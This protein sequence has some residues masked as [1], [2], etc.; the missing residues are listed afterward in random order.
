MKSVISK[1]KIKFD[2]IHNWEIGYGMNWRYQ[3]LNV[4]LYPE[5]Q[6]CVTRRW[7]YTPAKSSSA[8]H[9]IMSVQCQY[10]SSTARWLAGIINFDNTCCMSFC[11]NDMCCSSLPIWYHLVEKKKT[12]MAGPG[13]EI[14]DLQC[15]SRTASNYVPPCST[16][17]M[18]IN[19]AL[20]V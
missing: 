11:C 2:S 15:N 18:F 6:Y 19:K 16:F 4:M 20:A 10:R 9:H 3:L 1:L 8:P 14:G 12:I 5:I 7:K 17:H 13:F